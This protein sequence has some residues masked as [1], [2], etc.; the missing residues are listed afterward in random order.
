MPRL[1]AWPSRADRNT[2]RG[3][4]PRTGSSHDRAASLRPELQKR[5]WAGLDDGPAGIIAER[6]LAF[7]VAGYVR[8]RAVCRPWR[9]CCTEPLSH[10]CLDCRFHP[11]RWTMLQEELATPSRHCFLNTSTGQCVQVD[12]PELCDHEL[13][14]LTPEGLLVLAHKPSCGTTLCMFNPL[15]RHLMHLLPLSKLLP[16]GYQDLLPESDD[17]LLGRNF[18]A[19][20]SGI[21]NENSTV[22]FCLSMLNTIGM[23]KPGDDHWTLLHCDGSDMTAPIMFEGR[24][25]YVA[26]NDAIMVLEMS[27]PRLEVA[28]KLNMSVSPMADS[29]HLFNNSGELMLVHRSNHIRKLVD[30]PRVAAAIGVDFVMWNNMR[31]V[32]ENNTHL[33]NHVSYMPNDEGEILTGSST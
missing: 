2:E 14:A 28:A 26:N 22:V 11:R 1:A 3:G 27:T 10:S 20:G 13:L 16:S 33:Y 31:R 24:L 5:D 30:T 21:A 18:V 6:V 15:T 32:Y 23:T 25:Y 17:L 7:D 9:Q 4:P 8:F 12:I 29:L 19:W